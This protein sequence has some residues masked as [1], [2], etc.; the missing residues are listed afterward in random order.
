MANTNT[1]RSVD[2]FDQ[3]ADDRAMAVEDRST[4][5]QYCRL[6][7]EA[8]EAAGNTHVFSSAK[9][10]RMRS[11]HSTPPRDLFT[12]PWFA[13]KPWLVQEAIDWFEVYGRTR[14]TFTDWRVL[15][16]AQRAELAEY[17]AA[18]S[19][20]LETLAY[21]RD[22][23]Y[24]RGAL[25]SESRAAGATWEQ[26]CVATG[27][28]RMQAHTLAKQADAAAVESAECARLSE[29]LGEEVF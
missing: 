4:F 2:G 22:M 13:I 16:R 1:P 28:S 24:R 9:A 10:L 23:M 21:M 8:Y 12:G 3:A 25:I 11:R 6:E 26:I 27:L 5:D 17:N 19:D 20:P 18:G 7:I 14:Y 15:Q 29:L